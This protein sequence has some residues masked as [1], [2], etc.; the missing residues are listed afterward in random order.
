MQPAD[1]DPCF[2]H[3]ALHDEFEDDGLKIMAFPSNQF[4]D[5][6]IGTNAE[7]HE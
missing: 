3:Q 6:E 4:K 7:I 2:F 1:A 5:A